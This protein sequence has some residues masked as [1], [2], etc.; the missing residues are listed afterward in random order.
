MIIQQQNNHH[1]INKIQKSLFL[2]ALFFGLIISLK[3]IYLT[4][5]IDWFAKTN[6]NIIYQL[7]TDIS[8]TKQFNKGLNYDSR[9]AR[10]TS[11]RKTS[12]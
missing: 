7:G 4:L 8:K 2:K 12:S 9:N 3:R 10:N 1:I 6:Y 5:S 11:Y